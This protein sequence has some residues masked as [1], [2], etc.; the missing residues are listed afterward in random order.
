LKR[1]NKSTSEEKKL[2]ESIEICGTRDV[3]L[4]GADLHQKMATGEKS[5][6]FPH[7]VRFLT[8]EKLNQVVVI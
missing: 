1:P 4:T 8:V 3:S 5:E 6:C 7:F 2:K